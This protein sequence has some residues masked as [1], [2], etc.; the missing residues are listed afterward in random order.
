MLVSKA[1]HNSAVHIRDESLQS[2]LRDMWT[3]RI[4][5]ASTYILYYL[6]AV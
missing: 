6:S 5:L 1:F 3:C 2:G 4:T